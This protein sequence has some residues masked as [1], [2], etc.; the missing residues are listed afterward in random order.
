MSELII[1][2]DQR[3]ISRDVFCRV[4]KAVVFI[5]AFYI[6]RHRIENAKYKTIAID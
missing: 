1:W 3:E 2:W 5:V 6:N 4:L